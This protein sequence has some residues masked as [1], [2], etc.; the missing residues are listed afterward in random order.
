MNVPADEQRLAT[1]LDR[2]ASQVTTPHDGRA[3]VAQRLVVRR[4]RRRTTVVAGVALLAA[5]LGV[6]LTHLPD[7][8]RSGVSTAGLADH[9]GG[10]SRSP[11]DGSGVEAASIPDLTVDLPGMTL[12]GA[13][14]S[15]PTATDQR[16]G[17]PG[18]FYYFQSFRRASDDW[19]LPG[20]FVFTT[21]PESR[22]EIGERSP[23]DQVTTVDING[24]TGYLHLPEVGLTALGWR[25]DD[26]TTAFVVAPGMAPDDLVALGRRMQPRTDRQGWA[27]PGLPDGLVPVID[28]ANTPRPF[29]GNH[30]LRFEDDASGIELNSSQST[31][32]AFEERV[33]DYLNSAESVE[34]T[35]V[36]GQPAVVIRS[37]YDTRV[38]WYEPNVDVENYLIIDGTAQDH[39]DDVI[40]G[41]T[42]LTPADWDRL[43][44]STETTFWDGDTPSS[45][46]TPSN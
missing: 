27:V 41:L 33:A 23:A 6:G 11:S 7:T 42:E 32:V 1:A 29:T 9:S 2:F 14:I 43:L 17:D 37:A 36:R 30:S 40:A 18:G 45:T 22:F 39:V 31:P 24:H 34:N 46:S 20:V 19:R 8:D 12:V 44:A 3:R 26:G 35:T 38:L 15:A 13:D 5:G 28:A 10:D 4:R 16:A 21:T 25:L